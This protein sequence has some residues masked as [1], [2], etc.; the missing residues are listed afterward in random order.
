MK[1]RHNQPISLSTPAPSPAARCALL[2]LALLLVLAAAACSRAAP[3]DQALAATPTITAAEG[4]TDDMAAP[5]ALPV[6]GTTIL[7]EGELV[8]ATP[9]LPLAF[10]AGGRL[11]QVHVDNGDKVA[12]GDLLAELDDEDLRDA[13]ADA[14]L[15]LRQAQNSLAQAQLN[16]DTLLN[17]EPDPALV[18]QAE[19]NL[20][21]AEA[22]LENAQGQDSVAYSNLTAARVRLEQAERSLERAQADYDSAFDPGRDWEQYID[23]P[24]CR[25]G[26]QHPN[27]TGEP[28]SDRIKR[29]RDLA[30]IVLANA[31]DELEVARASYNLAAAGLNDDSAVSAEA[32]VAGA[33]QALDQALTGPSADDIAS[34]KLQV[35]QAGLSLEQA[36]IAQEK[37]ASAVAEAQLVAPQ[38]G[39]VL[40]V[41]A[42]PGS[43]VSAGAPVITLLDTSSLQFHTNNFSERDLAQIAPGQPATIT[44]KAYPNDPLAGQVL[45]VAPIAAGAIGDA[46]T[47]TV[48]IILEPAD[49][50]LL[51]GMTGRV[52]IEAS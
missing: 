5:T 15:A 49:V 45:R 27:C 29:E 26:E 32:S 33:Q 3:G 46:A 11:L 36:Q 18:A 14:E 16:L 38:A 22:G 7:A 23:D 35:E 31:Q 52:E 37:A 17:W 51:P 20:A 40:A 34:A 50:D 19:A 39:T 42:A 24:S 13:V 8:A 28:Y 4:A 6:R 48:V 21:A 9:Q 44:L 1:I 25:T 47:F 41:D 10:A 2:L 12:A 43:F 30:P